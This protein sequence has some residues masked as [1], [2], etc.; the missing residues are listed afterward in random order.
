MN[1]DERSENGNERKR[2]MTAGSELNEG[3]LADEGIQFRELWELVKK[4][5]MIL[6]YFAGFVLLAAL[7]RVQLQTPMYKAH[8]TLLI[9]RE[10]SRQLNIINQYS[11]IDSDWSGQYKNTQLRVLTSRSLARKVVEELERLPVADRKQPAAEGKMKPGRP[12]ETEAEDPERRMSYAVSSFLGNLGIEN[13]DETRLVSVSYVSSDPKLAARSVNLL[14]DKFIEFNL[15]IKGQSIRQASEFLTVQIED[16]RRVL[17]QKEQE[18]QEYGKRKELYYIRGEDSTVVQKL[19]DLNA[20]F[21]AAQIDRVNREATYR[22]LK[23]KTYDNYSEVRSSAII[24]GLKQEYSAKESEYKRKSQ[25]FQD[26]YPEMQR[27]KTQ[28]EGLQKRVNEE[29]ADIARKVLN[30]AEAEYQSALKKET[31][32]QEMLDQQKGSVVSSNANAIYYNSLKIE[33]ENMRGLL[34]H[35]TRKQ[36][37][38]MLSSRLEGLETS[39]IMIVDR[40]EVP[41]TPF[42][43]NK[44]RSLLMALMLG[45][46]GGIFIIFAL[47]YLDDT[48]KSPEDVQKLLR[49]PAL[50]FIPDTSV[51]ARYSAYHPYYSER[52]KPPAADR[53][54]SVDLSNLKEPE[55]LVAEHYRYV[56]TS[57][58]LAPDKPPKVMVA[59]SAL[60]QEGKTATTINLA[61]A[62]A[63]LGKKV[64]IMD[65]DM[66]RPRIHKVFRIKNTSGISTFLAG[67]GRIEEI[68][69]RYPGEPNLHVLT[70]GPIPP[71]PMELVVS[72]GMRELMAVLQKHYDFILIDTPPLMAGADAI[73]LGEQSDG[74]ILVTLGGKTPRKTI[75]K[76]R[77]EIAKFNIKMLGVILNKVNVRKH[78]AGYYS[79][80]YKYGGDD[81]SED[82][83]N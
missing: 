21:T 29:T 27:L 2:A 70:S 48:V 7:V 77:D 71:N 44:Q 26:S 43:P 32:L 23:G 1:P 59:T 45:I 72:R 55:S 37:E 67:R 76:A 11:V 8:G 83:S 73:L 40:A 66:R 65:A 28:L 52:K 9:E 39:N 31:Y 22:E 15:E 4:Q 56:R 24:T 63:Q 81:S 12:G 74:I 60:P 13:I 50:G 30:Q 68:I 53:S 75:E 62:F 19:S 5:R 33:V 64:L 82:N 25:I 14:F 58:L 78:R 61:V 51:A 17:A 10:G 57:L 54:R 38:S 36:K 47:N 46:G 49:L 80:S 20:A 79:Y 3:I 42:S 6:F 35:L 16:T 41:G 18:L 34:D 69:Y